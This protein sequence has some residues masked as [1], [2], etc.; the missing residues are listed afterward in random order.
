MIAR[1]LAG[2]SLL[3]V[4]A[5]G[6]AEGEGPQNEMAA[7]PPEQASAGGEPEPAPAPKPAAQAAPAAE[8]QEAAAGK[9]LKSETVEGSFVRW[10]QG[11]YVWAALKLKDREEIGAWADAPVGYFL[12]AHKGRPLTLRVETVMEDIPEAGGEMEIQRVADARL[13]S[14]TVQ[15]WWAGLTDEQKKAAEQELEAAIQAD[16]SEEEASA[17]PEPFL[18]SVVETM[19]G[20]AMPPAWP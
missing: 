7:G 15:S 18:S 17:T 10:D 5:C 12:Q 8:K 14:L 19:N 13:G 9:V 11:D 1:C 6:G 3:I 2:I 16:A 20:S 4:A